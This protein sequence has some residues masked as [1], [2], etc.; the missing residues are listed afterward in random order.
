MGITAWYRLRAHI[1]D[2]VCDL[3]VELWYP[4]GA[5]ASKGCTVRAL[6]PHMIWVQT[7]VS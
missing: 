5:A 6:K 2:D 7:G 1:D 3:D 4:R